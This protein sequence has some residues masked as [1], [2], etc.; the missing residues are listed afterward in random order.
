MV[1]WTTSTRAVLK[2]PKFWDIR[3]NIKQIHEE[4]KKK[5][6]LRL[7]ETTPTREKENSVTQ[8]KIL[9]NVRLPIYRGWHNI[10]IIQC[11]TSDL[12]LMTLQCLHF[13]ASSQVPNQ[14]HCVHPPWHK[15]TFRIFLIRWNP[16]Q[17]TNKT[18]MAPQY[19]R[20]KILSL[21]WGI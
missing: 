20:R 14:D 12:Q 13:L 11:D 9:R 3:I 6:L 4:K 2:L 17:W 16:C 10:L 7:L 5:S 8:M 15:S 21:V 1:R 18:C 19:F